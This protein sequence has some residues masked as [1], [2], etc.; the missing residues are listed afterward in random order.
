MQR[1]DQFIPF[2]EHLAA[3]S[4]EA[5]LPFFDNKNVVVE[6]KTDETPVTIADRNA[7]TVMRQLIEQAYPDHGI[8]GEEFGHIN[9]DAEFVWIL[10]PIDGTKSFATSCPLFG[11]LIAL[12]HNGQ[13]VLGAINLPVLRKLLIGDGTQTTLN[14]QPVRV[15]E[16]NSLSEATLLNTDILLVEHYRNITGFERL[17]HKVKLFRTWGDCYAY[18][19]VATGWADI[20]VDPIME[21]WDIQALIPIIRGA[22]GII[23]A[24]DGSDPVNAN[25]TVAASPA[26]HKQV[27][28]EL[29]QT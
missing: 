24:W 28:E 16:R 14:G 15:R 29:N 13:P 20:A 12:R 3:M 9:A 25:S 8:I 17:I 5:I 23:T 21:V 18:Y 2:I 4:A 26:L 22:G 6:S 11:T 7:E 27:I 19:L 1:Y 10:D